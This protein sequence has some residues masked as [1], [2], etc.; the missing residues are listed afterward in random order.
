MLRIIL[1]CGLAG[2]VVVGLALFLGMQNYEEGDSHTTGTIFG[3]AS[4]LVALTGVFIGIKHYRDTHLGGVI[5]FLPA[6]LMGLAI[7]AVASLGW[8]IGWEAALATTKIDFAGMMQEYQVS[9]ARESGATEEE[10]AKVVA[11]AEAFARMYANPLIR[12][13]ITFIEM[14]PVGIVVSLVS[15]GLLRNERFLPARRAA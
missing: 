14:F 6:F 2:A 11:D 12:M 4:I 3:Y 8:V 5:K 10:I 13:G 1:T 15:A 9:A 7:S